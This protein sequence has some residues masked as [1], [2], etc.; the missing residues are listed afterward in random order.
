MICNIRI[1]NNFV[2]VISFFNH[3][4]INIYSIYGK[5]KGN[6]HII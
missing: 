3:I 6:P 4:N 2:G 1:L 5:S